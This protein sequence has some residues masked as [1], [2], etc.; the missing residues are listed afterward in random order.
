MMVFAFYCALHITQLALH[1]ALT[2]RNEAQ[3][4]AHHHVGMSKCPLVTFS[5]L[6][7]SILAIAFIISLQ[8]LTANSFWDSY[9]MLY[10]VHLATLDTTLALI[11]YGSCA[12]VQAIKIKNFFGEKE[13]KYL[14]PFAWVG[15]FFSVMMFCL[16]VTH[17]VCIIW[18]PGKE[19]IA[20][21][22]VLSLYW[23]TC[24]MLPLIH[25]MVMRQTTSKEEDVFDSVINS[26]QLHESNT[27]Y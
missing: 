8:N 4:R 24:L 10:A 14:K 22:Q 18:Y 23:S 7:G 2:L 25:L 26:E 6:L 17:M 19:V 3:L 11:L 13:R 27:I 16:L 21:I 9:F 15:L 12:V 5:V 20:W 1:N